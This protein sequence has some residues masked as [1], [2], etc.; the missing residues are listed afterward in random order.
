MVNQIED[1]FF[2]SYEDALKLAKEA[3]FLDRFESKLQIC[4]YGSKTNVETSQQYP[5]LIYLPENNF[6]EILI[7]N[8][9]RPP[10]KFVSNNK[11][12]YEALLCKYEWQ[13]KAQYELVIEDINKKTLSF[14]EPLRIYISAD[15][16]G[17][18]VLNIYQLL[19]QAFKDNGYET[20]FDINCCVSLMD[21]F[22]RVNSIKEFNP[23]IVININRIRNNIINPNTFNFIWFM[24]PTICLYDST[25]L[26]YRERDVFFYLIDN[27]K[28]A[29]IE[30]KI[31]NKKL[32][33]QSFKTDKK[34][35]Y[36]LD[37]VHKK[38]LITFIG[39]DYF[40]ACDPT[41]KYANSTAILKE[42][43]DLF[44][45]NE[46][47]KD[48]LAL[49]ADKYFKENK[50][51]SVEHLEMFIF[52]AIVR[53]EI[54][55]WAA[56]LEDIKLEIYGEGWGSYPEL[57][58]YYKGSLSSKS[59]LLTTYNRS[60]YTLLAHPEYYYQQRLL[61]ASAC[62][63]IPVIYEGINNTEV[64]NHRKHSLTFTTKEQLAKLT[65]SKPELDPKVIAQDYSYDALVKEIIA[66][67][68]EQQRDK[69]SV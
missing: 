3:N 61:E 49:L 14:D 20:K 57:E 56:Q 15:Y 23:H 47:T 66:H 60:K 25:E 62:G 7:K 32:I 45:S 38:N 9:L 39:N 24:D 2:D 12:K 53:L 69:H 54:L 19:N 59:E 50:I 40:K 68:F 44:N 13:K 18:V 42:L 55:K 51:T 30:K 22:K 27:F 35:F 33:K 8:H 36:L 16:K 29:L 10:T 52:P 48:M 5:N 46:L 43:S 65:T 26:T 31:P 64:F 17:K 28:K 1:T 4:Y 37:K 58:P 41:Y 21:D 34:S 63:S 11:Q 6:V 67:T